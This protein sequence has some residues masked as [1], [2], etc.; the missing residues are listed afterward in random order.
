MIK[1]IEGTNVLLAIFALA[2]LV[3]AIASLGFG[4][5]TA[6]I[7]PQDVYDMGKFWDHMV[8]TFFMLLSIVPLVVLF[9]MRRVLKE[10][11]GS[12]RETLA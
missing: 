6:V 4:F 1:R 5:Y 7:N 11:F 9:A 3:A 8:G 2:L 12:D 10:H